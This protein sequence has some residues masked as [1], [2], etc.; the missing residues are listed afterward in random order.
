MNEAKT[1]GVNPKDLLGI[2][3]APLHLVP[4]A[5]ALWVSQVLG[6]S[7]GLLPSVATGLLKKV[8]YGPYNW[9]EKPVRLSIYLDA[10]ERHLLALKD[11]QDCDEESGFLHMAHI[12]ANCAIYFDAKQ[13]RCLVD[14]RT[15]KPGAA[16]DIIKAMTLGE[17]KW[18]CPRCG[19][20]QDPRA[21]YK[22]MG[23]CMSCKDDHDDFFGLA[24]GGATVD[25][26]QGPAPIRPGPNRNKTLEPR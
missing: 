26:G 24:D 11:G 9:R 22:P 25:V 3:K 17:P 13:L 8:A 10:I 23:V 15:W 18:K 14:D 20:L 7:A 21:E 12:A 2:K 4:P 19:K 1:E 6:F 16:S 5:L